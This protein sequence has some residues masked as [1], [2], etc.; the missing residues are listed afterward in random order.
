MRGDERYTTM[1]QPKLNG[2][3]RI[4]N[5]PHYLIRK[6]QRRVNKRFFANPDFIRWPRH[7]FG[8]IP[9][10]VDDDGELVTT[11]YVSCASKH[12]QSKSIL[13]MDISDF[14]GNVHQDHVYKVFLNL[15]S[16]PE[17][18]SKILTDLCTL[19]GSLPQGGL[20]SSYLASLCLHDKEGSVVRRLENK[21]LVY[22]RLVDDIT[23]S[24]HVANYNFSYAKKIITD[25]L[26]EKDLPIN[27][28]KTIV[29]RLSTE[30]LTVHG[31]R[32]GFKEPRLPAGEVKRIRASVQSMEQLA[33]EP[34]YRVSHAYR[35]D[36][37]RCM[38]RVNK[39]SRVGHKQHSILVRRLKSIRP[40]PSRADLDRLEVMVSR[41]EKDHAE[42][43]ATFWYWKRYHRAHE[44]LNVLQ[45]IYIAKA[46][47]FR[48]RLK[49]VKPL[50]DS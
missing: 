17:D 46:K 19:R 24:S 37:N 26:I 20:T 49:K 1:R 48:E 16:F 5:N 22:T 36:Y 34:N 39:L 13:K 21:G 18:V 6:I 31:L 9:N 38:G 7:I 10:Y 3:D 11:D 50:Y 28:D 32:V 47:K 27:E 8:C 29:Q 2:S 40:L 42:K 44:R 15:L 4:V 35:R 14:F 25:M 33:R 30:P 23:V 12:C 41:L 43:R 45:L